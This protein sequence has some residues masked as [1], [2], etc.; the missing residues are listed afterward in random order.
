MNEP[1]NWKA[2]AEKAE[3]ELERTQKQA[4]EMRDALECQVSVCGSCHPGELCK[5]PC[6]CSC[7]GCHAWD[8]RAR[9]LSSDAGQHYH[10]R[11]EYKELAEVLIEIDTEAR[12]CLERDESEIDCELIRDF[13]R[14]PLNSG[15]SKGLIE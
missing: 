11:D 10:H 4:A 8:L 2:R 3:V 5:E 14:H 7:G 15:R 1:I 9:A 13:C 6:F 12:L